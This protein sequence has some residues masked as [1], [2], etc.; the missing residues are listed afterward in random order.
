MKTLTK[1]EF[2]K[3]Y[4]ISGEMKFDE[5]KKEEEFFSAIKRD[6]AE[7]S[8]RYGEIINEP[9]SG[10]LAETEKG[11]RATGEIAGGIGNVIGEGLTRIPYIGTG[12]QKFAG[13]VKGGF[14]AITNKLGGT[15]F[16]QEAAGGLEKDSALEKGLSIAESGGEIAGNILALDIGTGAGKA[17]AKKSATTAKEAVEGAIDVGGAAT[18]RIS[19]QAGSAIRDI[20]PTKQTI[21]DHQIAKALNL[22]PVQDLAKIEAKTG[23]PV[24]QWIANNNLIGTN[25]ASTEALIKKFTNE[26]YNKVRA[27]IAKVDKVYKLPPKPPKKRG[28][29][30]NIKV[31]E[32]ELPVGIF[33]P[34]HLERVI[35]QLGGELQG[36]IGLEKNFA[37]VSG[38][39]DKLRKEGVTL[40][41]IQRVKELIDDY[42]SLY[43]QA[44]D[45]QA[46][47]AK[48]GLANVRKEVQTFIEEEVKNATG[49]DIRLMNKHVA[50]GKEI[51][52]AIARRSSRG[53]TRQFFTWRDVSVGLGLTFLGGPFVGIGAVIIEKLMSSPS[54]RLRMARYLDTLSDVEKRA[55]SE[56]IKN[57]T[58]P[59]KIQNIIDGK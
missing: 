53:L 38:L 47:L 27:E 23:N 32:P 2:R 16:M 54:A 11:V 35:E 5:S 58:V 39:L 52:A 30:S 9:G 46:G 24:G 37:E 7:R 19:K 33:T 48:Q 57:G 10:F 50:T 29:I 17:L 31:P 40:K 15:K 36:K 42:E 6:L 13:A 12:V 44:G 25:K 34:Q 4:G 51:Q 14:D 8:Q 20:V 18:K 26:N 49:A 55:I 43:T 28:V 22:S 41:E 56:Q 3:R 45:V 59:V 1:E 21:I